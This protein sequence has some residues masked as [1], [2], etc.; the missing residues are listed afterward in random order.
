MEFSTFLLIMIINVVW[1]VMFIRLG[2]RNSEL[3]EELN[4]ALKSSNI[5]NE[6]FLRKCREIKEM[7]KEKAKHHAKISALWGVIRAEDTNK[8]LSESP[9]IS[10]KEIHF[11]LEEY[12]PF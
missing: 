8:A 12:L 11:E 10:D 1:S 7:R 3:K 5:A 6:A 2:M 9:H 4:K